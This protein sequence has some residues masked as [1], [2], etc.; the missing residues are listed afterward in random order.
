MGRARMLDLKERSNATRQETQ[1]EQQI[2]QVV[3]FERE[4]TRTVREDADSRSEYLA[5]LKSVA[6]LAHRETKPSVLSH[7]V[8]AK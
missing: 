1:S 6:G 2:Q 5:Y 7:E 8:F 4:S 3:R